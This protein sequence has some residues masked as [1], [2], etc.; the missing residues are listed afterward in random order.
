MLTG[1]L[2]HIVISMLPVKF[3]IHL[4]TDAQLRLF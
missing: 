3:D 2:L 1:M 4:I